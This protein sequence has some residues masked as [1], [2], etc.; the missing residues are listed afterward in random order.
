MD[1]VFDMVAKNTVGELVVVQEHLVASLCQHE[2]QDASI[3]C[4]T[5]TAV[6]DK[7]IVLLCCHRFI[8]MKY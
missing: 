4:T 5:G 6:A 2:L 7:D 8:V 1:S 3:L